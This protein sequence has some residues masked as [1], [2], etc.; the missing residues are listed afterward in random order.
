VAIGIFAAFSLVAARAVNI[1]C[2]VGFQPA[3]L[4]TA[5][6]TA[7]LLGVGFLAIAVVDR[8][9]PDLARRLESRLMILLGWAVSVMI[10]VGIVLFLGRIAYSTWTAVAG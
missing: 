8:Y 7:G 3:V 2:G 1:V 6:V 10:L 4:V 5:T 9:E